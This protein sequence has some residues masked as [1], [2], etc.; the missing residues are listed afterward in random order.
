MPSWLVSYPGV[1]PTSRVMGALAESTYT[2]AAT[3]ALV[4]DHY[5][6]L[7]EDAGL[8][9]QPRAAWGPRFVAMRPSAICSY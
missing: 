5:R 9:F 8:R 4:V 1:T 6:K 7:F 3:P 2:T